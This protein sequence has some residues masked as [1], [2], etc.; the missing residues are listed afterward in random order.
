MVVA[1][2]AWR[3]EPSGYHRWFR[4]SMRATLAITAALVF[5]VFAGSALTRALLGVA[6]AMMPLAPH[7][8]ADLTGPGDAQGALAT[9]FAFQASFLLA[10]GVSMVAGWP[11][12][13]RA[14]A[15]L[16]VA[17]LFFLVVLVEITDRTGVMPHALLLRAWAVG[18]PVAIALVLLRL[19]P[20]SESPALRLLPDGPA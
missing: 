17:Q 1:W 15:V 14:L 3:R 7:A 13:L 2:L 10:L 4:A 9:L 8:L 20:S 5:A 19:R 12:L 6:G 16:F 11:R 18:L